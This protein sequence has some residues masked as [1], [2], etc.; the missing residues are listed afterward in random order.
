MTFKST[1]RN[2]L[3]VAFTVVHGCFRKIATS[4]VYLKVKELRQDPTDGFFMPV[5]T[6]H[7][8][9]IKPT[10]ILSTPGVKRYLQQ[11]GTGHGNQIF[12][13]K[14][15]PKRSSKKNGLMLTKCNFLSVFQHNTS[16]KRS[17]D[18]KKINFY[19][20]LTQK[21]IAK[22]IFRKNQWIMGEIF[23]KCTKKIEKNEKNRL[24]CDCF[25]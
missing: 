11:F 2:V 13:E 15:T 7:N 19:K 6:G 1:V 21:K 23:W 20:F 5:E 3:A 8:P 16:H 17:W 4:V 24:F 25:F 18:L 9:F 12:H 10:F 14:W 22:N